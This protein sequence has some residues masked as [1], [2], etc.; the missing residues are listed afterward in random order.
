MKLA[1]LLMQSVFS[2]FIGEE[3]TLVLNQKDSSTLITGTWQ[4]L[5]CSLADKVFCDL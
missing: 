4:E 2:A 1:G 3:V 5:C